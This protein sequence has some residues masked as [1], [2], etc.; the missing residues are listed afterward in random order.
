MRCCRFFGC[1]R[2]AH[3]VWAFCFHT[4]VISDCSVDQPLV[5]DSAPW[6]DDD[7]NLCDSLC[8]GLFLLDAPHAENRNNY[9]I[10]EDSGFVESP[11][12][13]INLPGRSFRK[14]DARRPRALSRS[15][16]VAS[17]AKRYVP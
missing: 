6:I 13:L 4:K 12:N 15:A 10:L 1:L 11:L 16:S 17:K 2:K 5:P 9:R 14:R 7:S 8:L 3:A